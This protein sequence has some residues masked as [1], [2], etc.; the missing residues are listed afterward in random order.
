MFSDEHS[1]F[2]KGVDF[3][4]NMKQ[5]V[6]TFKDFDKLDKILDLDTTTID[7]IKKDVILNRNDPSIRLLNILQ[8]RTKQLEISKIVH[9]MQDDKI[10]ELRSVIDSFKKKVVGI[11][12][13]PDDEPK[14]SFVDHQLMNTEPLSQHLVYKL[15]NFIGKIENYQLNETP[16]NLTTI[17]NSVSKKLNV[18][19]ENNLRKKA[20]QLIVPP[21]AKMTM[22]IV[23]TVDPYVKAERNFLTFKSHSVNIFDRI[24]CKT[25]TKGS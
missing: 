20:Q 9:K 6:K 15:H 25:E 22:E 4:G 7:E 1:I 3:S 24:H 21:P 12:G 5:S 16:N 17:Y 8:S 2:A 11:V 14:R 10:T 18:N 19:L 13:Y 23:E